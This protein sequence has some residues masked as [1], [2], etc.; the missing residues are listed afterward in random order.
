MLVLSRK[1]GE[2]IHIGAD[3]II[4]VE[5]IEGNKIRLGIEAPREVVIMRGE[6]IDEHDRLDEARLAA[7]TRMASEAQE[8]REAEGD[9]CGPLTADDLEHLAR[10]NR[11]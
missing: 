2:S 8:W 5:R 4:T 9:G 11:D 3:I 6:L 1:A 7:V 10:R